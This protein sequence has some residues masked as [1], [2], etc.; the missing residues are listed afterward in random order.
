MNQ[1]QEKQTLPRL[2]SKALREIRKEQSS[3]K[4]IIPRAP[5]KRLV[6]ETIQDLGKSDMRVRK[7]ALEAL[8]TQTEEYLIDMF[9]DVNLVAIQCKRETIFKDDVN[10]WK[11]ITSE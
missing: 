5:F 8:Q 6:E 3:S 10:L 9:H 7:G 4:L 1:L 11:T 2:K